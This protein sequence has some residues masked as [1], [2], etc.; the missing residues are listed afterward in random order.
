MI[1]Q[2]VSHYKCNTGWQKVSTFRHYCAN[3]ADGLWSNVQK[4]C[5]K[6][7]GIKEKQ[8]NKYNKLK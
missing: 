8:Y 4:Y 6:D 7:D 5:A 2:R 1:D 3:F